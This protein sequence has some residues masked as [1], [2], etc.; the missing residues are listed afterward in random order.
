MSRTDKRIG[1]KT[2]LPGKRAGATECRTDVKTGKDA[3]RRGATAELI[4]EASKALSQL[5]VSPAA[6]N[7]G[8]SNNHISKKGL[9]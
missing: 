8:S 6:P 5:P 7:Q 4:A 9:G 3:P 2:F 1:A